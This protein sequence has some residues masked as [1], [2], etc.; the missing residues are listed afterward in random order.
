MASICEE[1]E[2]T[3]SIYKETETGGVYGPRTTRH[4]RMLYGSAKRS[5][6]EALAS[7]AVFLASNLRARCIV[8][9]HCSL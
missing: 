9:M 5:V 7:S 4:T 8:V 6:I 1:A 2:K 3:S